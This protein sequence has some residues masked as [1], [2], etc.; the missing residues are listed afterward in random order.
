MNSKGLTYIIIGASL[1]CAWAY[2]LKHAADGLEWAVTIFCIVASFWV[3]T[4]A[5][6]YMGASIAYVLYTG[7]GT[8]FVVLLDMVTTVQAGGAIDFVKLF[9]VVTLMSGVIVIKSAK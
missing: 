5:F 6:K 4:K 1:E 9:F 3:F 2:G 7:L 8:L